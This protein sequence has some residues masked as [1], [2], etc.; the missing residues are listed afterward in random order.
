MLFYL[1]GYICF[2]K[3]SH[4][5]ANLSNVL[6]FARVTILPLLFI[7]VFFTTRASQMVYFLYS[8]Q[9]KK[10]NSFKTF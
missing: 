2:I 8:E 7:V 10:G 4:Q 6:I 9:R 1:N 3:S 5:F